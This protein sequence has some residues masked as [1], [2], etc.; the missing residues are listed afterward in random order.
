M[1]ATSASVR[2]RLRVGGQVREMA[3]IRVKGRQGGLYCSEDESQPSAYRSNG[4]KTVGRIEMG[5]I[6]MGR[7]IITTQKYI[8]SI[9]KIHL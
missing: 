3:R 4:Q 2:L 5:P 9:R 6:E 1:G 7:T 8:F